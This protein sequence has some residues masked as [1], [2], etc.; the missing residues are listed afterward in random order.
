[1]SVVNVL[2]NEINKAKAFYSEYLAGK[3]GDILKG[4][5]FMFFAL[6]NIFKDKALAA[7][8]KGIFDSSYRGEKFDY[9]VDAIYITGADAFIENPEELDA[10]ND[11]SKYKIQLFQC[12]RG[13]GISQAD[14]LKLKRGIKKIL[15]D[16]S[17]TE[18]DN[19][20]LY[21]RMSALN[22]IKS[23]LF[24][25]VNIKNIEVQIHLVFGGIEA[26]IHA[27][28]ILT[29]ELKKI[30]VLLTK[31]GYSYA[32]IIITDG[33]TLMKAASGH[34]Q[35]AVIVECKKPSDI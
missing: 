5:E 21:N 18:E 22:E 11:E 1:M 16:K 27:D 17:I 35:R 24:S 30:K 20:Y 13:N 8:E 2:D 33:A 19:L 7:I 6:S 29:D 25:S 15:I 23:R 9:G 32:N 3:N 26:N 28:K 14:L 12:K 10:C 31:N 4:A 34:N